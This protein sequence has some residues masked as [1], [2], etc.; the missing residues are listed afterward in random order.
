MK[1][2]ITITILFL[3]ISISQA[4]GL[5][6]CE[7]NPSEWNYCE[8]TYT[9]SSGATYKGRWIN[10]MRNGQ[11]IYTSEIGS[12]YVGQFKDDDRHGRGTFTRGDNGV[13]SAGIWSHDKLIKEEDQSHLNRASG[14]PP[15]EPKVDE[16]KVKKGFGGL[17][18]KFLGA[19]E[20]GL[21]ILDPDDK[22]TKWHNCKGSIT[23][24]KR[25]DMVA[26]ENKHFKH[27]VGDYRD[28]YRHG[29]GTM[30]YMDGN[31]YEGQ[32][33]HGQ[34]SGSGTYTEIDTGAKYVG[35]WKD[36][37]QSGSGSQKI[38]NDKLTGQWKHGQMY[39][40]TISPIQ[41]SS[42]GGGG[43]K[44]SDQFNNQIYS[45]D[46]IEPADKICDKRRCSRDEQIEESCTKISSA[47]EYKRC[48]KLWGIF[49]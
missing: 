31:I 40:G 41:K 24:S 44:L 22:E 33:K 45:V 19:L 43:N 23:Y 42:S 47:A 10:G 39:K 26:G 18:S 3:L 21:D 12:T 15:C 25:I 48:Q 11:G 7:G 4:W 6:P 2:P 13:E 36:G 16:K 49:K 46:T 1:N 20:K 5:V 9:Y 38:G 37:Q 27:Y 29:R 28:G 30:E 17:G 8:G 34:P 35:Q 14:L 32:W